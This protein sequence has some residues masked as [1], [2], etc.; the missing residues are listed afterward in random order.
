METNLNKDAIVIFGNCNFKISKINMGT[1]EVCFKFG[2][3]ESK[4]RNYN[5]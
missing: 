3:V 5:R 4:R 2:I 1:L